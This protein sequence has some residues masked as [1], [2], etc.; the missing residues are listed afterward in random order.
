MLG[1]P[2]QGGTPGEGDNLDPNMEFVQGIKTLEKVDRKTGK[3]DYDTALA[4]FRSAV[5][6]KPDFANA[7]ANAGWT[8]EQMGDMDKPLAFTRRLMKPIQPRIS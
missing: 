3:V 1:C 8:A 6:L 5:N 2:K 4:Y 7:A